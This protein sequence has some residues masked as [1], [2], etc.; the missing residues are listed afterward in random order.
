MSVLG[1]VRNRVRGQGMKPRTGS[2]APSRDDRVPALRRRVDELAERV[3]QL[4]GRVGELEEELLD[5]RSQGRRVGEISDLVTE[6]LAHEASRRD[7]EF[8]RILEKYRP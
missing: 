6:L 7:P 8:Q 1:R 5:A 3:E 4:T 2:G